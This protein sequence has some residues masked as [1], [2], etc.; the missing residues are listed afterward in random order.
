MN[1]AERCDKAKRIIQEW[2]DKQG[3]ERCWYYPDLFN[4]L[5]VLFSVKPTKNPSLPTLEEFREGCRRYQQEEYAK[6]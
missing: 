1:D 5:A 2:T 3:H 6:K 4:R